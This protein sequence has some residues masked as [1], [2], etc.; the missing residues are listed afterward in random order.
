LPGSI[1]LDDAPGPERLL[2]ALT[3]RPIVASELRVAALAHRP[4]GG[5]SQFGGA[6]ALLFWTTIEKD[7]PPRGSPG[8]P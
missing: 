7:P 6:K 2:V 5:A 3:D 8:A 4:E 1:V